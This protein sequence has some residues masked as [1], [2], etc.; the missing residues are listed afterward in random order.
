MRFMNLKKSL[1]I[2]NTDILVRLQFL[3]IVFVLGDN[4]DNSQD[5]RYIGFIPKKIL[6]EE[7]K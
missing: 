1:S 6:L 3:V 4:R 2:Y 5:S 7:Q